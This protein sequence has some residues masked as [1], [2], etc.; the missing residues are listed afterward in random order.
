MAQKFSKTAGHFLPT[1]FY[2][3]FF[4]Q[5]RTFV[6]KS[7][8]VLAGATAAVASN[9]YAQGTDETIKAVIIG[10]GGRGT[11]AAANFLKNPN[12]KIIAVGDV[13]PDQKEAALQRYGLG[14]EAGFDGFDAYRKAI[15][16]AVANGAVYAILTTPPGFRP[17]HYKY[18]VEKGLNCFLEKPCCVDSYGYRMLMDVNK[19]A[20][21]K[22]LKVG[23][24]MQRR[25][26]LTYLDGISEILDDKKWGDILY[27]RVYWNMGG[28]PVRGT[29]QEPTEM[30]RQIRN[31]YYFVWLCGDNILEQHVH[32]LDIG[33]I[34]M[35][36]RDP[37]YH[38]T[39]C[40]G[41]GGRA[42]RYFGGPT[43][44][45][46]EIF[47]Y[48]FVE[49]EYAD[50]R[51]MYSQS[52]QVAGTWNCVNEFACGTKG[53]G[54]VAR[55]KKRGEQ[56]LDPYDVEHTDLINAIK[57]NQKY[58]EGWAGA[59]ASM[60]GIMGRMATY[61]GQV[62]TWDQAVNN[63]KTYMI[64]ENHDALTLDSDPPVLPNADG[65]YDAPIPG[66]SKDV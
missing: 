37:L 53:S 52:R 7:G 39:Q 4:M 47:A 60:I 28:I 41:M 9:A 51:R 40:N 30:Q 11:G 54:P 2:R 55:A 62:V 6:T 64:Y 13:F 29:G 46:G 33:N 21:E 25:H 1:L 3:S 31:R 34:I 56:P 58:N 22:N 43:P 14:P 18:A 66:V 35:G 38:P 27:T 59:T 24:G 48:H 36:N 12:T 10:C 16:Y 23:V 45:V 20:D 42:P 65:L 63:G 19:L 61:S 15:D 49:Y 8:I 50:G 5:N 26:Q 57:Q 44:R 17:I 32:N